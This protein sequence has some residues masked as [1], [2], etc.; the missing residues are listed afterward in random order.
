MRTLSTRLRLFVLLLGGALLAGSPAGA[1]KTF[2][3]VGGNIHEQ[4]TRRVLPGLGFTEAAIY[5]IDKGNQMQD[6]WPKSDFFDE[7]HHFDNN[8]INSS[9]VYA[10]TEFNEVVALA[11]QIVPK[12]SSRA[13]KKAAKK[14]LKQAWTKWGRMLHP[15][16]DFYSH[17]NYLELTLLR[18]GVNPDAIAPITGPTGPPGCAPGISSP[19]QS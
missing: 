10:R 16:Q 17:S 7:T 4:L 9:R 5:R 15:V 11:S 2:R 1:F 12:S 6:E 8:A 14:A 19:R 13:D 3:A 18:G